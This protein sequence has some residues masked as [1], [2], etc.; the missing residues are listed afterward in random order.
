L[1]RYTLLFLSGLLLFFLVSCN[2]SQIN[3]GTSVKVTGI[4]KPGDCNSC[5][6]EKTY[7]PRDHVDTDD[8]MG[9]DCSACHDAG[10]TSLYAKIPLSHKHNLEGIACRG[11]HGDTDAPKA[12][13]SKVCLNCHNDINSLIEATGELELNPHFSPHDGKIPDCNRCHHQHKSSENYCS[14]CHSIE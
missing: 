9:N 7:L 8:M 3:K 14:Q 12:V 6:K 2:I 10:S 11:C 13:G 4:Q 1:H 5:H